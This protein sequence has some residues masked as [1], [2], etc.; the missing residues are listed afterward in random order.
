MRVIIGRMSVDYT[1]RGN[2][3]L[4]AAVRALIIKSD[5]AVLV[6]S[7]DGTKP[8]NYMSGGNQAIFTRRGR[9]HIW[10]FQTRHEQITVR[11]H[12]LISDQEFPLDRTEPGLRRHGTEADLQ[13]FLFA[14]PDTL[15]TGITALAREFRT[16]RGPIDLLCQ[17][18]DGTHLVVEVKRVASTAAVD[19][20]RRY[21][22]ALNAT[23]ELGLV[24]GMIA[25][26]EFRPAALSL[27]AAHQI[28]CITIPSTWNQ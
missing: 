9:Q 5:G 23:R 27:A 20:V 12:T 2:T 8:L 15:G 22:D 24:T 14:H 6:M 1:G 19:Q 21:V 17:T 11:I 7:D 26:L 3:H 4:P 13:A 25:A 10:T 18:L 16:S 28:T